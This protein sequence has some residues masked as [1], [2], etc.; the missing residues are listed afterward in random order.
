MLAL[1]T[2]PNVDARGEQLR[3]FREALGFHQSEVARRAG[4]GWKREY[5]DRVEKGEHRLTT[6][7]SRVCTARGLGLTL[8]EFDSFL[9]GKLGFDEAVRRATARMTPEE[10]ERIVKRKARKKAESRSETANGDPSDDAAVQERW[11]AVLRRLV[12]HEG[13][14]HALAPKL[15]YEQGR[16]SQVLSGDRVTAD[17]KLAI[18]RVSGWI[19]PDLLAD[20]EI[21][22]LRAALQ[23]HGPPPEPEVERPRWGERE[24]WPELLAAA[25]LE[26]PSP[27]WVQEKVASMRYELR[28]EPRPHTLAVILK[29][30][31]ENEW[32]MRPK[33]P[34]VE[35]AAP[36]SP[37]ATQAASRAR[38][39]CSRAR[40]RDAPTCGR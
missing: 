12:E 21:A 22:S 25:L 39:A 14:Q 34:R 27:Q 4:D 28:S 10:V 20:A 16:I 38:R 2:N 18:V 15:G 8:G 40:R 32:E 1:G 36:P 33:T 26:E 23:A 3:A 19:P 29:W 13:S 6:E 5:V 9:A 35:T 24:D 17:M 37:R 11:R 31:R 7:E 30:V